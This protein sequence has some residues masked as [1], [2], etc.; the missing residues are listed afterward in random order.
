MATLRVE[1]QASRQAVAN[2]ATWMNPPVAPAAQWAPAPPKNKWPPKAP[3]PLIAV[4]VAI[5]L[6]AVTGALPGFLVAP[7]APQQWHHQQQRRQGGRQM[8]RQCGLQAWSIQE[9]SGIWSAAPT[10]RRARPTSWRQRH[11]QQVHTLVPHINK[12]LC[13]AGCSLIWQS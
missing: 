1:V 6:R 10:L 13:E 7:I 11:R 5:P 9:I 12:E 8:P 4:Y 2:S 3:S